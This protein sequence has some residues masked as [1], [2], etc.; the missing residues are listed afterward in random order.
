MSMSLYMSL[1]V[2]YNHFHFQ[3]CFFYY[4]FNLFLLQTVATIS[5]FITDVNDE[6]P[7]FD[8]KLYQII[9]PEVILT[10]LI[11]INLMNRQIANCF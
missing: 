11:L 1:S 5:I 7:V 3:R 8:D 6:D 2:L 10:L 4:Y 9:L